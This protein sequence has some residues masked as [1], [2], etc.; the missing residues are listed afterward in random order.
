MAN[1]NIFEL[2]DN[3]SAGNPRFSSQKPK[4]RRDFLHFLEVNEYFGAKKTRSNKALSISQSD[5]ERIRP[6]LELWL[7]SYGAGSAEKL[8]LLTERLTALFPETGTM[9]DKFVGYSQVGS[10]IAWKLADYL[11]FA[12][13]SEIADM[14]SGELDRLAADMDK[15]LPLLSA[16]LFSE[17]LMYARECG[18]PSNGWVYGFNSRKETESDGAYATPDFLKMAYIVFNEESW[19]KERLIECFYPHIIANS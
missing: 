7:R 17:F 14:D 11:C 1:V 15:E 8:S 12:L 3:L 9:F 5:A 18:N 10:S 6:N 19:D 16:R 13:D 4:C 2:A